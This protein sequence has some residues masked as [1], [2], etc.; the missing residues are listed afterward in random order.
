MYLNRVVYV[1][2]RG[3]RVARAGTWTA[4]SRKCTP[5]PHAQ[6]I[7]YPFL[8]PSSLSGVLSESRVSFFDVFDFGPT[9]PPRRAGLPQHPHASR[10]RVPATAPRPPGSQRDRPSHAPG[11]R[12]RRGPVQSDPPKVWILCVY[13]T[14]VK[15]VGPY[16]YTC[17]MYAQIVVAHAIKSTPLRRTT[18]TATFRPQARPTPSWAVATGNTGWRRLG[19]T[20]RSLRWMG[21]LRARS[22]DEATQQRPARRQSPRPRP[23]QNGGEASRLWARGDTRSLHLWLNFGDRASRRAADAA[24][25][26]AP[27]WGRGQGRGQA[28]VSPSPSP[29]KLP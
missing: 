11:P 8:G 3:S 16:L 23:Q 5:R 9:R 17:Y 14:R 4:R 18:A 26:L 15:Y 12:R 6:G 28:Q 10:H 25:P 24:P 22:R 13:T 2:L 29:Y 7:F 20:R 1:A 21:R 19:R 27:G